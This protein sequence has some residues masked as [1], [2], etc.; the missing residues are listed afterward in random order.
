ME[1]FEHLLNNHANSEPHLSTA[2]VMKIY[3]G[4]KSSI[5]EL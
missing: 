2:E 4:L 5:S 3:K 1:A